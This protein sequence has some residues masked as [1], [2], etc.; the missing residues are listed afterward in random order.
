MK[1]GKKPATSDHRDL[2]FAKYRIDTTL[3][4][5][6]ASFG[7]EKLVKEWGMLGNDTAGDCVFAGAAHE[8]LLWNAEAGTHTDFH[9]AVVLSDYSKV[10][11][12]KSW[13]PTTDQGADVRKALKY[14]QDT[15]ILD[16]YGKRHKI[17]AYLA[18]EPGNWDHL[19]EA[20]YLGGAV[21]I[22]LDFPTS[23]MDQFERGK[24]WSVVRG[25]PSDGG[26]YVSLVAYR[27]GKLKCITW[28]E[29]QLMTKGFYMS[30]CDEAWCMFSP[31][32]L[33]NG[34]SLEGLDTVQLQ[35]DLIACAA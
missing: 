32:A 28:G 18:L 33:K 11:G 27:G 21:G 6:P 4:P 35:R 34:K 12:Y 25:S 23:A 16:A 30:K 17:G 7:H 31:E 3:P 26:H 22:G 8:T 13:D 2:K 1:L 5:R 20:L 15:G 10:T 29:E 24:P 9:D 14:R 19:L